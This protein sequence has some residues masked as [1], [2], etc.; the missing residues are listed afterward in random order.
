MSTI[1][2]KASSPPHTVRTQPPKGLR[3]KLLARA[4]KN[5]RALVQG[6]G[7]KTLVAFLLG[8]LSALWLFSDRIGE[9]GIPGIGGAAGPQGPRGEQGL[10]GLMGP[11]GLSGLQGTQGLT[12]ATGPKGDQG[13]TGAAGAP[14]P[15]GPQGYSGPMGPTGERG[16]KGEEG[17][18][19]LRGSSGA[20]GNVKTRALGDALTISQAEKPVLT[21]PTIFVSEGNRVLILVTGAL[22]K[23]EG[24]TA[25]K[26]YFSLRRGETLLA[27]VILNLQVLSQPLASSNYGPLAITVVDEPGNGPVVYTLFGAVDYGAS[28]VISRSITVLEVH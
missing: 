14:G 27:P 7:W 16:P 23:D 19:G 5:L 13:P 22:V 1:A 6:T 11:Q 15:M 9:R 24:G 28:S 26:A 10:V 17:E 18:P 8:A 4:R 21:S 2:S 12:G 3:Q 25:R 20:L